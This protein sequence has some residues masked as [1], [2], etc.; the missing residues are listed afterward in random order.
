MRSKRHRSILAGIGNAF[1]AAQ[2]ARARVPVMVETGLFDVACGGD[3]DGFL[4]SR[5]HISAARRL[6]SI[7]RGG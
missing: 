6:S 2:L 5:E 7:L 4:L 3:C 1:F